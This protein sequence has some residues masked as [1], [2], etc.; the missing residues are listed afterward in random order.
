MIKLKLTLKCMG[1][2]VLLCI[3]QQELRAF[4]EGL[5]A[6]TNVAMWVDEMASFIA[7]GLWMAAY[8]DWVLKAQ[9]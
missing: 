5:G 7:G 2:L 6:S 9:A 4:A 8:Y 3:F 1:L